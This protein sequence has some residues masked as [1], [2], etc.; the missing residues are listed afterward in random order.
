MSLVP[1]YQF[2]SPNFLRHAHYE[3]QFVTLLLFCQFVAMMR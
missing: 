3:F 1:V 2:L